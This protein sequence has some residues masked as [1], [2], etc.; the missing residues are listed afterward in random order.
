MARYF[1]VLTIFLWLVGWSTASAANDYRPLRIAVAAFHHE[2]TTFSPEKA[3]I[4]N[5]DP[6]FFAGDDLLELSETMEGF[7]KVAGEH[8]GVEVIP[9]RS[10]G[11]VVGGSSRGHITSRAYEKYVGVILDELKDAGDI[12]AVYL[13]LHGCAAVE[14]IDRP[15]AELAKRVRKVV[16]KD[17]P[18]AGTFDP[19]GNEDDHFLKHADFS[20]SMKY[21]PHYDGNLQGARAARLLIR[22]ARGDYVST[23]ATRRPGIITPTVL[24]WTGADPWMSIV[25]RALVWEAREPDVFVSVFFGFPWN[26]SVD[27]GATV[28]VMTNNDQKLADKIAQDLSDYMWRRRGELFSVPIFKPD[29][30]VAKAIEATKAKATPVVLADYSDRSGDATHILSE[31]VKQDLSGVL[32]ATL[33]DERT[34]DALEEAGAKRGD[35]FDRAVGGFVNP[36]ASGKPVRIR[37][38]IRYLGKSSFDS[39]NIRVALIEFGKGNTLVITDQLVQ[40]MYPQGLY[41]FGVLNTNDYTSWV[42]KSRAHFRRGFDDTGYAK[43]I[44]IVDAPGPFLGTVHLDALDYKNVE[45][46]NLFPFSEGGVQAAAQAAD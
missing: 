30:A 34:I 24:Q 46:D 2:A 5:F 12:D 17:V 39:S 20:L 6:E 13:D 11:S 23:R 1:S 26:D 28:Q 31:I 16:G 33:R 38:K 7:V 41:R 40:I 14:G 21:F 10:F 35:S 29:V 18:I 32:Y 15:E 22:A 4:D 19:H 27:A 8:K 44:M 37:G 9:L 45:L 43:T 42:L 25:Q 3:D 36:A